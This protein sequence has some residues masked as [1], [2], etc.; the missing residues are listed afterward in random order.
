MKLTESDIK[1]IAS[2]HQPA[3]SHWRNFSGDTYLTQHLP[4]SDFQQGCDGQG[5]KFASE[6]M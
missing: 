2:G 5:S 6:T 3:T 4:G 1:L